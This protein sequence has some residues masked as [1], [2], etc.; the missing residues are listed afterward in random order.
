MAATARKL[1]KTALGACYRR[2]SYRKSASVAVFATA[3]KP[4]RHIYPGFGMKRYQIVAHAFEN[5]QREG[6]APKTYQRP[7]L[8]A[9]E[10]KTRK[11]TLMALRD[12]IQARIAAEK[13]TTRNGFVKPTP[14]RY[15]A[16]FWKGQNWKSTPACRH[17][18]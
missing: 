2:I 8:T 16:L 13:K 5:Q 18:T 10:Q 4:A 17:G 15:D 9:K 3:R 1:P 14:P 6:D 7:Q 11:L 12:K